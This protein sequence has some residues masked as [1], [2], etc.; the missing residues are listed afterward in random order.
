MLD[1]DA[2]PIL[3][4]NKHVF[5]LL[6]SLEDIDNLR[7]CTNMQ[8]NDNFRIHIVSNK[9]TIDFYIL[10]PFQFTC[11]LLRNFFVSYYLSTSTFNEKLYFQSQFYSTY[12]LFIF[13]RSIPLHI[14]WSFNAINLWTTTFLKLCDF[15]KVDI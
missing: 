8:R 7:I 15:F 10:P 3:W 1:E 2:T 4:S 5:I 6:I 9:M 13:P 14:F 12:L 11:P